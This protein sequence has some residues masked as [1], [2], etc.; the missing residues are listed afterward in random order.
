MPSGVH[1]YCAARYHLLFWILLIH[2]LYGCIAYHEKIGT[3]TPDRRSLRSNTG[4]LLRALSLL[5][6]LSFIISI[7]ILNVGC[8]C[9]ASTVTP[10]MKGYI[11][12]RTAQGF[13]RFDQMGTLKGMPS[14]WC[15]TLPV[16]CQ[17]KLS[18]L[19]RSSSA[20]YDS[21]NISKEHDS[22]KWRQMG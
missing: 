5:V 6:C 15:R 1:N 19:L 17:M 8:C 12:E 7:F 10:N 3:S 13:C 2:S 21:P 11:N 20:E 4:S 16:L 9:H 14:A 18:Q 22:A